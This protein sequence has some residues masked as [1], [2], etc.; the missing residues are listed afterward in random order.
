[1][2]RAF[3]TETAII[4][5]FLR[6]TMDGEILDMAEARQC[7]VEPAPQI[8]SV[9]KGFHGEV[10]TVNARSVMFTEGRPIPVK[11]RV[12]IGNQI[13][14]VIHCDAYHG[15]PGSYLEVYLA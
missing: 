4:E 15:F 8:E 11:S 10:E 1:M 6:E 5:P 9:L 2:I 3:L 13:Y 7:R 12:T 14:K